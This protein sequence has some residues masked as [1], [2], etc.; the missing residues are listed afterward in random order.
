MI[1]DD[2]RDIRETLAEVLEDEGFLVVTAANG[3][4]ALDLLA[5]APL[6]NV[7]LLDLMMPVMDGFEFRVA[8]KMAA[9][10]APIPVVIITAGGAP[11]GGALEPTAVVRKPLNVPRL[12]DAIRACH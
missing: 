9:E 3:A 8:Q 1:V 2:D 11:P 10:L 6:P 12:L 4:E 5:S 7:I